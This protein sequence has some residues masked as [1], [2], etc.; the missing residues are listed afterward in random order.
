MRQFSLERSDL[1]RTVIAYGVTLAALALLGLVLA[2]WTWA[3]FAP[4]AKPRLRS[5]ADSVSDRASAAV[6][7]GGSQRER[8]AVSSAGDAIKLFGVVAATGGRPGYAVVQLD[9]RHSVTVHEGEEV[10]PGIRL[11][12]VQADHVVLM[13]NGIRETLSWPRKNESSSIG[14]RPPSIVKR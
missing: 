11:A 1:T 14:N 10:A 7:F 4:Q 12:E 8:S 3:W 6:L 5:A 9:A 13:R 2:Y